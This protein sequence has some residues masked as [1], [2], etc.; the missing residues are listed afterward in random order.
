MTTLEA[1]KQSVERLSPEEL[2]EFRCWLAELDAQPSAADSLDRFAAEAFRIKGKLAPL[3]PEAVANFGRWVTESYTQSQT[4]K[5]DQFAWE[6]LKIK[7][8]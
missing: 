7:G 2:A 3:S 6:A 1:L 8:K 4:D 5:F